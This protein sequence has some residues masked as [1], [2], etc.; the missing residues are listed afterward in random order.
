MIHDFLFYIFVMTTIISEDSTFDAFIRIVQTSCIALVPTLTIK[1][2]DTGDRTLDNTLITFV[3]GLST[4]LITGLCMGL[5]NKNN[6]AFK[7]RFIIEKIKQ[8][9]FKYDY[10]DFVYHGF[11][12]YELPI[13]ELTNTK[14]RV[15]VYLKMSELLTK[16]QRINIVSWLNKSILVKKYV[17]YI[18]F[19]PYEY[20]VGI[21]TAFTNFNKS[22]MAYPFYYVNTDI[23]YWD[24]FEPTTHDV[25]F[26]STSQK[27]LDFFV[28]ILKKEQL[29]SENLNPFKPSEQKQIVERKIE[30]YEYCP[31]NSV[32][33]MAYPNTKRSF[34]SLFFTQK[35]KLLRMVQKFADGTLYPKHVHVDNKLG[36]L[37]YGPP[38]TGKS[39]FVIALANY[40]QKHIIIVDMTKIITCNDFN[41]LMKMGKDHILL[42]EE[43][44]CILGVLKKRDSSEPTL[45]SKI[46]EDYNTLM[47][48]FINTD[49][50]I[51]KKQIREKLD[52]H[53]HNKAN[54]LQLGYVLQRLDGIFNETG[55]VIIGCTNH[56]EL[57]DPALLRPG[58]FGIKIELGLC[59]KQM[60]TDIITYY[61]ELDNIQKKRISETDL[62]ENHYSPA[63]LIQRIQMHYE[64]EEDKNICIDKL[65]HDLRTR[66]G[67][68]K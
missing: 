17:P 11:L 51:E 42:F 12:T 13:M 20:G 28:N 62:P 46:D 56:P 31:I 61:M 63:E 22:G 8:S 7:I 18:E 30:I 34:D 4:I 55:R 65:I 49:D 57:I 48:L 9:L 29:L 43:M 24:M 41:N 10:T 3:T 21:S 25:R 33:F 53:K 26:S 19:L 60:I 15:S 16:Q 50:P 23:I 52:V 44:D 14:N 59:T 64:E 39:A 2:I 40:L 36:I 68:Q 54:A 35:D 1:Y 27:A 66:A 38:G 6:I 5:Q 32:K 37:L 47:T 67:I 45:Q 58:R